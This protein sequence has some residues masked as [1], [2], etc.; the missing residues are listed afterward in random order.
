MEHDILDQLSLPKLKF[1]AQRGDA[2]AQCNLATLLMSSGDYSPAV[3]WYQLA[4]QQG[5]ALAQ[6]NLGCLFLEGKGVKQDFSEAKK[7]FEEAAK[8]EYVNAIY[9]LGYLNENGLGCKRDTAKAYSLYKEAAKHGDS[10]AKHKLIEMER[11]KGPKILKTILMK[12]GW[13]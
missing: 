7:W 5:H 13:K 9:N 10:D 12:L 11:R 8:Q 1:S 2:N 4:A 3:T 6:Y